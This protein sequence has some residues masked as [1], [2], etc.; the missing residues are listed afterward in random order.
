MKTIWIELHASLPTTTYYTK[1]AGHS[2]E[3]QARQR[4][5]QLAGFSLLEKFRVKQGLWGTWVF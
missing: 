4:S 3:D 1:A 2:C 5:R